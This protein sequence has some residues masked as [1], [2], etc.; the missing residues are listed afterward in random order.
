MAM[1]KH[2]KFYLCYFRTGGLSRSFHSSEVMLAMAKLFMYVLPVVLQ[3]MQL[4]PKVQQ[5]GMIA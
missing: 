3:D 2:S 5:L 1:V 4:V